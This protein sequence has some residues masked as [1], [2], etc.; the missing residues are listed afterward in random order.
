MSGA[1]VRTS[2]CRCRIASPRCTVFQQND[3][4]GEPVEPSHA[5]M[6]PFA[7]AVADFAL[8]ADA[9]PVLERVLS[10]PLVQARVGTALHIEVELPVDDKKG[11]FHPS[12]FAESDG[13]F[14]KI[15]SSR[16]LALV[17]RIN[18]FGT[19][20]VSKNA[21]VRTAGPVWKRLIKG[22]LCR[23]YIRRFR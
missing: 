6:L 14:L 8:A 10:L 13:Q 11:S 20:L 2:R 4:D 18:G 16:I 5:I 22:G 21:T 23:R 9:K 19:R 1:T 12:D 3:D 17:N 7:G 15:T